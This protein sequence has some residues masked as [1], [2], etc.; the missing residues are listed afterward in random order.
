MRK[1]LLVGT[2]AAVAVGLTATGMLTSAGAAGSCPREWPKPGKTYTVKVLLT[3]KLN[4]QQGKLTG[5]V[6]EACTA[7]GIPA[8]YYEGTCQEAG[9][10]HIRRPR[11]GKPDKKVGEVFDYPR[12]DSQG[13]NIWSH[14]ARPFKGMRVYA[15]RYGYRLPNKP[16]RCTSPRTRTVFVR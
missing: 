11:R 10:I 6:S 16:V 7:T 4:R 2:V 8:G 14:R 9:A 12:T 5:T 15:M 1:L 3:I 13:R